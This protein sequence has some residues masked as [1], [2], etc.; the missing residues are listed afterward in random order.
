M[1]PNAPYGMKNL[2]HFSHGE[3]CG[4]KIMLPCQTY[5]DKELLSLLLM[6]TLFNNYGGLVTNESNT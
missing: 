4:I 3:N 1:T 5:K 6:H 2:Q